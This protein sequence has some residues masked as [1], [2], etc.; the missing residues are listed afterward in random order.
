MGPSHVLQLAQINITATYYNKGDI[1][2]STW[3]RVRKEL[4][5]QVWLLT[6]FMSPRELWWK[7]HPPTPRECGLLSVLCV[8][9]WW[10][11]S[12]YL[13][14]WTMAHCFVKLLCINLNIDDIYLVLFLGSCFHCYGSLC[15]DG[16][17]VRHVYVT[18]PHIKQT[19]RL[20]R[21]SLGRDLPHTSLKFIARER[22]Y[23]YVSS[24]KKE[25]QKAGLVWTPSTHIFSCCFYS[26][27]FAVINLS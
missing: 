3:L 12:V 10:L 25:Y 15:S 14:W 27:F 24:D 4:T 1:W 18:S 21:A 22:V 20:R 8:S 16:C 7:S 9:D 2:F 17:L 11:C 13:E 5:E 19:L 26:A 23:P 6:T